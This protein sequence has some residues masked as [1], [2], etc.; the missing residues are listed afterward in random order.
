MIFC[1][2]AQEDPTPY[3]IPEGYILLRKT[4]AKRMKKRCAALFHLIHH[5]LIDP[6]VARSSVASMLGWIK[7]ANSNNFKVAVDIYKL[8][9]EV[10]EYDEAKRSRQ[11]I[12]GSVQN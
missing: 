9:D 12:S 4:T 6:S 3:V 7:W 2:N 8:Y 1:F 11:E 10:I 5:N